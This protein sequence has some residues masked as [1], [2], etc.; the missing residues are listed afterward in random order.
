MYFIFTLLS[1]FSSLII[2]LYYTFCKIISAEMQKKA[3]SEEAALISQDI[4]RCRD[5]S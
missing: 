5:N 3:A 1:L 4:L 2:H